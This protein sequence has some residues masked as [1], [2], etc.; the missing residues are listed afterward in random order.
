M[1]IQMNGRG[2]CRE[3]SIWIRN[4]ASTHTRP[5]FPRRHSCCRSRPI[6]PTIPAASSTSATITRESCFPR[7]T[8]RFAPGLTASPSSRGL[9]DIRWLIEKDGVRVELCLVLPVDDVAELWTAKITNTTSAAEEAILRAVLPGRLH[10]LDEP[11]RTFRR[12]SQRRYSAPRSRPIRRSSSI[13]KNQH[14][15]DITFLAANRR[16]DHFEV[17]QQATSRAKAACTAPSALA[18]GGHLRD[19]EAYYEIPACIMQWDLTI[20]GGGSEDFRFVFGPAKDESEIAALKAKYLDVDIEQVR[21]DYHAYVVEGAA[22]AA[23]TS[24]RRIRRSTMSS[25]TGC[26]A[27]CSTTATPT[28]S[29]PIPRPA[30]TCK[31]RWAC[32]F[33]RPEAARAVILHAVSQQHVSGKMPDGILLRP[34]AELKYINQV[35]HTD[36]RRLG[37]SSRPRP[38]STRRGD[39]SILDEMVAWTDDPTTGQRPRTCDARPAFPRGS[40]R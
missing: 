15:K 30:I 28:A 34:D 38:I 11:G 8:S 29:P 37:L 39:H 13:S 17:A 18:D 19:G 22:A 4:R 27:K 6:I 32:L 36:H 40:G 35:P 25:T 5:S 21:R 12:R 3:A 26:R 20:A 2:F 23:S 24:S 1:M 33:I 10:V 31:M 9:S 7:P 14:L 16:P